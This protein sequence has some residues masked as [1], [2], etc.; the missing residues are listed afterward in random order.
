MSLPNL[1]LSFGT[2]KRKQKLRTWKD[3]YCKDPV[4]G[5]DPKVGGGELFKYRIGRGG[6]RLG[7]SVH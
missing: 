5:K 6:G 3:R 7:S 2:S 4:V 1:N